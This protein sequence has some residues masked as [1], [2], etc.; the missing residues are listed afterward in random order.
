[1]NRFEGGLA[2]A[3]LGAALAASVC[4]SCD[5]G[6]GDPARWTP[7]SGISWDIR[8]IE[9]PTLDDVAGFDIQAL[10]VD[11]FDTDAEVVASLKAKG[12]AV[13]A[14]FS[15]GSW[16]DWRPD[17]GDFPSSTLGSDYEG[18]EG[19]RWLDIRASDA[20]APIMRARLDLA[21][22]KGFDGVD[23]DNVDGYSNVTGFD[24][25]AADQLAFNRWLADEAHARGL[26]VGLKN[27][28]E[29][30]EQLEPSFDFT[31]TESCFAEGWSDL[32]QPFLD[33]GKPVLA[34]EYD[35]EMDEAEFLASVCPEA[36][37]IGASAIFKNRDLDAYVV[38][39]GE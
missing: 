15:A 24:I 23:P 9:P 25:S 12:I 8:L 7:T 34:I 28:P 30:A 18:W 32:V 2:A 14:Y 22:E 39:C 37:A 33:S 35:D 38:H 29:Q 6:S 13:I 20:L 10:D 21:V 11:L 26:A 4:A 5:G 17:A 1:M 31:V 19:E 36:R 3:A 16:E 27:D